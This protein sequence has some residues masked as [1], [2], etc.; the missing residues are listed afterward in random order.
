MAPRF[1]ERGI[2]S[3]SWRLEAHTKCSLVIFAS[4]PV[5]TKYGGHV[6]FFSRPME[7][8][9]EYFTLLCMW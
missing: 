9:G 6:F 1:A 4:S 7:P 5:R 3:Q 8:A 2:R